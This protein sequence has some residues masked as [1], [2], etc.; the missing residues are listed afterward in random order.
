MEISNSKSQ[1]DNYKLIYSPRTTYDSLKSLE[2]KLYIKLFQSFDQK[3]LTILQRHFK[4]HLGSI[5]K[6]LFICILKKHLSY[7]IPEIKNKSKILIKLLSKLFDEIDLDSNDIITWKEFSNF[8]V[9]FNGGKKLQNYFLKKYYQSKMNFTLNEKIEE[10]EDND[11]DYNAQKK[12]K[13][14][15]CFYIEKFRFLGLIRENS[16]KILFFNTETNGRLKLGID[17]S[18]IQKEIDKHALYELDIKIDNLLEKKDEEIL[19]NK[20]IFEEK[21]RQLMLKRNKRYNSN[22]KEKNNNSYENENDKKEMNDI[23]IKNNLNKST[24]VNK[25]LSSPISIKKKRILNIFSSKDMNNLSNRGNKKS[26]YIAST[27]FLDYY[28][29]LLISTTNNVISAWIY[30]EK[31]EYFENVNLINQNIENPFSKIDCIFEKNNILIPLFMTESTQYSMCF[32]DIS[33]CLFTGQTDGKIL[34]WDIIMDKP[35]LILDINDFNSKNNLMLPVLESNNS[36]QD[37]IRDVILKKGQ[38]D[39]N[40]IMKSFPENKRNTVSCLIFIDPLK[41]LC[42]AHYNGLIILWDIVYYKPKRIY[43][44]QKTGIYQI[45]YNK[46]YN[47]IYSCGFDHDIYVYDPYISNEAIYKLIGH[48]SSVNSIAL[49]NN[50]N[51]LISID[52]SGIIKIWDINN[53]FN[54]QTININDAALLKANN[55]YEREELVNKIYKKK[56][57]ANLHIQ[58]F[59]DLSKFL[60][61]GKK[62]LLLI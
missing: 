32:D 8:L 41:I 26:Y 20:E 22:S 3:T 7:S 51:E 37:D 4:E 42:S 38:N 28:N 15:Y 55:L 31:E 48:K 13:V 2:D 16:S 45:L 25:R 14:S 49:N 29:L 43:N 21:R 6:D 60:I 39:F 62:F 33:N 61:Y 35:I 46:D 5:S 19:K 12:E 17:L 30:K 59:P 53:F 9:N 58:T 27:L 10:D 18:L 11:I 44:D 34:K 54:F 24:N 56:I 50:N 47:H 36:N 1:N 23:K 57:S 52:I 40:K